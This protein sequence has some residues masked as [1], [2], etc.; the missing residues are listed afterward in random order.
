MSEARLWYARYFGQQTVLRGYENEI[1]LS[2][3]F[4]R[5]AT[6]HPI[7]TDLE[8]ARALSSAL[9]ALNLFMW[10]LYRCFTAKG[11]ELVPLFS[12]F[13]LLNQLGSVSYT[14]PRKFRERLESWL[15]LIRAMWPECPARIN[16]D[17]LS[18]AVNHA[19]AIASSPGS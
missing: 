9:A 18:L 15:V 4:Y 16:S 11:P 19:V 6:A 8:A 5:E 13:G 10:L 17:G 2:P 14:R 1:I 12:E 7:P 3:E